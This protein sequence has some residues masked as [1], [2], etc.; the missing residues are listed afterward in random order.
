MV[1]M[2]LVKADKQVSII[3]ASAAGLFAGEMMAKRGVDVRVFE[4]AEDLKPAERCLIVT[5]GYRDLL[6]PVGEHAT[7]NEVHRFELF[8]DGQVAHVELK[9][10]DVIIERSKL[11]PALADQAEKAGV[12]VELGQKFLGLSPNG[13]SVNFEVESKKT[14]ETTK[15]STETIIGA[16]G[17]ASKFRT[18]AGWPTQPTVPLC[19]AVIELPKGYDPH[20]SQIW[21]LPEDTPYFYWLIA[22]SPTTGV[23]GIIGEKGS[24]AKQTL[25]AFLDRKGFTAKEF[26]AAKIPAYRGWVP[27]HR[28]VGGADA[29]L[30]GDAAGQVKVSTVGGIVTGLKG[31]KGVAEAILNGGVKSRELKRLKKE[32]NLHLAVRKSLHRFT[33]DDYRDLLLLLNDSSRDALGSFHRDETGKLLRNLILKQPK[34]FLL[35]LRGLLTRNAFPEVLNED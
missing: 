27:T 14:G 31:A 29:Y 9:K 23:L 11:I 7:V 34:F 33:T 35:G 24:R 16:D 15:E 18:A 19:Q 4:A 28:K 13:R 21:F 3:G 10:P 17:A 25:E 6:G 32:L 20:T 26:Q 30:M 2:T 22:D 12:K 8:A 5:D 1:G